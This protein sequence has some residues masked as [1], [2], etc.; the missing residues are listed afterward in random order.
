MIKHIVMWSLKEEAEGKT[1]IENAK[2]IKSSLEGLVGNIKEIKAL[3]VGINVLEGL[4][5]MDVTLYTEFESV[6]DLNS[7]Q[8]NP[9]HVNAASYI[10]KVVNKRVCCDFEV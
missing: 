5:N 4:G 9:M 1:K 3:E 2:I 10:K 7:Y 6:D 8:V